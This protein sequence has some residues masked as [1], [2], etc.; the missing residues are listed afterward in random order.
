MKKLNSNSEMRSYIS[1]G[2]H[3]K[4]LEIYDGDPILT[5]TE[6][7]RGMVSSDFYGQFFE[8]FSLEKMASYFPREKELP[9]LSLL[10]AM[11]DELNQDDGENLPPGYEERLSTL[12]M[13]SPLGALNTEF[14]L[15]VSVL[16]DHIKDGALEYVVQDSGSGP[17]YLREERDLVLRLK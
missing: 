15:A 5:A 10:K 17:Q 16:N 12:L 1:A 7:F 2:I 8:I 14:A 11:C 4:F 3:A 6:G 9:Q 13:D